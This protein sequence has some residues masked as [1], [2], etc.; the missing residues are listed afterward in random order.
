[1]LGA[2]KPHDAVRSETRSGAA[3]LGRCRHPPTTARADLRR[4]D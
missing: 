2:T 3:R 4:V 1:M